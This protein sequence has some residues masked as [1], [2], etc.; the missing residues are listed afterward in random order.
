MD[1]LRGDGILPTLLC[2]AGET[3]ATRLRDGDTVLV[4]VLGAAPDGTVRVSLGRSA[5]V[6][7]RFLSNGHFAAGDSFTA[8]VRL[9]GGSVFLDPITGRQGDSRTAALDRLSLPDTDSSRFLVSFLTDSL[10]RLDAAFIR[11]ALALAARFPGRERRACEAAALLEMKG[12]GVTEESTERLMDILEGRVTGIDEGSSDPSSGSDSPLG[13]DAGSD[14]S[15]TAF[16]NHK[17]KHAL[18]WIILPFSQEV[19]NAR[20]SGSVRFLID[21]AKGS[22]AL[23]LVTAHDGTRCW[24]VKLRGNSCDFWVNPPFSSIKKG[25][26]AVY[27]TEALSQ[28]GFTYVRYAPTLEPEFPV[29]VTA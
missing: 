4:R 17:K 16:L 12:L 24:D 2:K 18:H 1:G 22:C 19:P 25:E 21:A 10:Y 14:L 20:L 23:T 29:D 11:R 13:S 27:L 7:A 8:R 6:T 15:F 3:A 28:T 26:I 9:S 5:V